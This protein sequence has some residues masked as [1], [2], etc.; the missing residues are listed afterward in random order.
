[1]DAEKKK[2]FTRRISQSNRSGLIVVMY[3]ML[4]TYIEE[5]AQEYASEN[6]EAFKE[7]VRHADRVAAELSEALD[8]RY[9]LAG[10][11]YPLY[12][13][14]RKSLMMCIVKNNIDGLKEAKRV[15]NPLYAAFEKVAAQDESEP[16]MQNT[17]QVYAGMTYGKETLKES[18]QEPD[19]SRGF[20]A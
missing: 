19:T 2:E 4:Y 3:D 11:L 20:F 8:F 6:Y 13:F 7:A 14:L 16:L 9:G 17:Q 1:M 12:T 18:Y 5:A 15:L 10:Q